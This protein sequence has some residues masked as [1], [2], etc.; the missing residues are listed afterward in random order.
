[1]LDKACHLIDWCDEADPVFANRNA[2]GKENVTRDHLY[3]MIAF[4]FGMAPWE[5][6]NP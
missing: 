3:S 2:L 1:M 4:M 5:E 6:P